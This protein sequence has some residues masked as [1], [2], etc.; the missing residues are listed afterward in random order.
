MS[1]S[2]T[3][4]KATSTKTAKVSTT[5]TTT[6]KAKASE[7]VEEVVEQV[8]EPTYGEI[9]SLQGITP[10]GLES[11]SGTVPFL[12]LVPAGSENI[13]G[14]GTMNVKKLEDFTDPVQVINVDSIRSNGVREPMKV[15]LSNRPEHLELLTPEGIQ[16]AVNQFGF[17]VAGLVFS[18]NFRHKVVELLAAKGEYPGTQDTKA[19]RLPVT[20]FVDTPEN[21]L[22]E[23]FFS[24]N[25]A[26]MGLADQLRAA[27]NARRV[28]ASRQGIEASE[29]SQKDI[30]SFMG[31][32]EQLYGILEK[33]LRFGPKV[34]DVAGS[35]V[36]QDA[37]NKVA[38]AF[39]GK[40]E[41]ALNRIV[42]GY[43]RLTAEE[44]TIASKRKNSKLRTVEA[45]AMA[46]VP[47]TSKEA[48]TATKVLSSIVPVLKSEPAKVVVSES[49]EEG[50]LSL[51]APTEA[52]KP[53]PIR[54]QSQETY[55]LITELAERKVITGEQAKAINAGLSQI[56]SNR[57]L[58]FPV[59]LL[60]S[61][62]KF[63][64]ADSDKV[65]ADQ[66]RGFSL[67]VNEQ[68]ARYTKKVYAELY[69]A[70]KVA[71]HETSEE[72]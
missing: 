41:Q 2:K 26:Q 22:F 50:S 36:T 58:G 18:G 56:Q 33:S 29:V 28:L 40:E 49:S 37:L 10:E 51:A 57:S 35:M 60:Q 47:L 11:F 69:E 27:S 16:L 3:T 42:K 52:P 19:I 6:R 46:G 4:A 21:R 39:P 71:V 14:E 20:S 59:A 43:E 53:Q 5:K 72:G 65:Q 8:A 24:N 31:L 34:F 63:Y 44:R 7:V 15:V 25:V 67:P 61:L 70:T 13:R 1:Q 66:D 12:M 30:A 32:S 38:N 62:E 9:I 17:P 48:G 45:L 23:G 55:L 64:G 54:S 68:S